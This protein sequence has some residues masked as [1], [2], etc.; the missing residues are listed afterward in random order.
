MEKKAISPGSARPREEARAKGKKASRRGMAREKA[1]KE[2]GR[3]A[4]VKVIRGASS[5]GA[6]TI[7]HE[8]V[9][10]GDR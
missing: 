1:T 9:P 4:L 8:I 7:S 2:L 3:G 10:V 6:W 5:A